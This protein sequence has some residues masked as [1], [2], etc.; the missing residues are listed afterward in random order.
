M[1]PCPTPGE[2]DGIDYDDVIGGGEATI[3]D[4][5]RCDVSDTHGGYRINARADSR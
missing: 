5:E 3:L 1:S 4:I 2:I